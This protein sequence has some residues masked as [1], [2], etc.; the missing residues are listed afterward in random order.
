MELIKKILS[1][2]IIT[3]FFVSCEKDNEDLISTTFYY[4]VD[5]YIINGAT[6]NN[7]NFTPSAIAVSNN[8]LYICNKTSIEIFDLLTKRKKGSIKKYKKNN[9]EIQLSSLTSIAIHNNRIYVGSQESRLFIFDQNSFEGI[10]MLGNGQ[11]W[12]TFVHVFGVAVN[13]EYIFVKEKNNSVKVFKTPEVNTESSWNPTPF[14]KLDLKSGGTE[15]YSMTVQ[16]GNLVIAGNSS[17]SYLYYNLNHITANASRSIENPLEP[18]QT[19][20]DNTKPTAISFSKEWA[21]TGE[22]ENNKNYLRVYPTNQ[23]MFLKYNNPIISSTNIIDSSA[24]GY[25]GSTAIFE[26]SIL[27][28]D[29][30]NKNIRVL[31]I[32]KAAITEQ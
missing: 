19:A 8:N 2:L 5:D 23:F 18:R 14:A 21:A 26:D 12:Q 30:T 9:T 13:D 7:A 32:K 16:D 3:I 27:I 31:K 24:F 17:K 4:P 6:F 22:I 20:F 29:T 11:W 25:I 15:N 28:L 1:L 10:N